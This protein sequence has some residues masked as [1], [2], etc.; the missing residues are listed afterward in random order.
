M[1]TIILGAGLVGGPMAIDLSKD[2]IIEDDWNKIQNFRTEVNKEL[3]KLRADGVIGSS[4]AAVVTLYCDEKVLPI[5]AKLKDEL[6][7]VLI[8]SEAK[9]EDITQ[10]PADAITAEIAGLK[11]TA[12][13]S[14]HKKCARCW[15][16][17]EDVGNDVKHE[18]LCTRCI[19]NIEGSGEQRQ[20]A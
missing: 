2:S 18:E 14:K 5:I 19:T 17:L 6:R 10:A 15:H 8:T 7:F 3:E 1:K 20:F 12:S 11:L 4:L 16:H 13:A 9:V